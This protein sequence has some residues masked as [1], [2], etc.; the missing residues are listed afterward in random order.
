[1][2]KHEKVEFQRIVRILKKRFPAKYPIRIRT[3]SLKGYHGLT[4]LCDGKEPHFLIII[5]K[6]R[7]DIMVAYLIHE[8]AHALSWNLW[9]NK[10]ENPNFHTD[11]WSL[12][13]KEIYNFLWDNHL[14]QE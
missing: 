14:T 4:K 2:E 7:F 11:K 10:W 3:R 13:Y 1:M 12:M 8:L 9:F 6:D 5:G